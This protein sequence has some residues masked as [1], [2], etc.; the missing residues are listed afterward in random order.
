MNSTILVTG[1]STGIGNLS[2]K[3][4]SEQLRIDFIKCIGLESL[5]TTV[6]KK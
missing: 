1:A 6:L 2:A 5:L 3:A 4:L